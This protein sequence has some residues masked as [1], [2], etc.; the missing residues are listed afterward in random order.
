ME[1]DVSRLVDEYKDLLETTAETT[2]RP[3]STRKTRKKTA[4]KAMGVTLDERINMA[5]FIEEV[6]QSRDQTE[7]KRKHE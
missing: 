7:T 4:V 3:V 2:M 6:G 1:S 5:T